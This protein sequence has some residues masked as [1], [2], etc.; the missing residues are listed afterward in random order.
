MSARDD[1]PGECGGYTL[2]EVSIS[3]VVVLVLLLACLST[4][5]LVAGT[6]DTVDRRSEADTLVQRSMEQIDE[7]LRP[8]HAASLRTRATAGDVAAAAAA[9]LTPPAVGDLVAVRQHQPRRSLEWTAPAGPPSIAPTRP[10]VV[11]RLECVR[12]PS[13]LENGIDDDGDDLVDEQ[14][15]LLTVG[16]RAVPLLEHVLDASFEA[17]GRTVRVYVRAARRDAQGRQHVAA[18]A[19]DVWLRN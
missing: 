7:L 19:F 8:A 15:L 4:G 5:K 9:G 3:A 17:D 14:S 2:L 6:V 13:E 11:R 10:I 1:C 18:R 12:D 16:G